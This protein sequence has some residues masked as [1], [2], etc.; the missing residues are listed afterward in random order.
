MANAWHAAHV[1]EELGQDREIGASPKGSWSRFDRVG[2]R[3]GL[4]G[5]PTGPVRYLACAAP[6]LP[7]E[8]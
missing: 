2:E 3:S 8:A 1:A 6:L 5:S 4:D 7:L